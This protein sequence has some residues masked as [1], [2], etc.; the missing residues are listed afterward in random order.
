MLAAALR[1]AA[2]LVRRTVARWKQRQLERATY[3]T[4]QGLDTRT[5]RDLGFH[6]SE[7]MSVAAE[8]AGTAE[9]TRARLLQEPNGRHV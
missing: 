8:V 6:R 4:L 3:E 7:L 2:A 5:L 1:G 9:F